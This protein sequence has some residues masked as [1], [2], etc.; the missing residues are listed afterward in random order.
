MH[1]SNDNGGGNKRTS[2]SSIIEQIGSD[3]Y[4][5]LKLSRERSRSNTQLDSSS[6][7]SAGNSEDKGKSKWCCCC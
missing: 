4:K 6:A 5:P 2:P 7:I 1:S 3:K